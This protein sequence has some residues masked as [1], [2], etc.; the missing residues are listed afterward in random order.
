LAY[1]SL[2]LTESFQKPSQS[3]SKS[4]KTLGD[5]VDRSTRY[6]GQ[7]LEEAKSPQG[8]LMTLKAYKFVLSNISLHTRFIYCVLSILA[9]LYISIPSESIGKY[10]FGGTL[11]PPEELVD[12]WKRSGISIEVRK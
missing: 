7:V 10:I 6:K 11:C 3:E 12:E 8:I 4:N 2:E 5:G 1:L 9:S